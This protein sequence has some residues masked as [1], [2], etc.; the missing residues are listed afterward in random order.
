MIFN[1]KEKWV[2]VFLL[3]YLIFVLICSSAIS[4]GEAFGHDYSNNDNLN[5]GT[6][7]SSVGSN[8]DWLARVTIRKAAGNSNSQLRSRLLRVFTFA[9]TIVMAIY[10]M[11]ANLKNKNNKNPTM[12]NL[13]LLKLRI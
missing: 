9:G 13:V 10:L 7:F 4:A 3:T 5:S 2:K 11:R 6:Y 12:K 8:I 1:L